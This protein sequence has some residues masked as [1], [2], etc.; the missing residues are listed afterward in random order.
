[1]LVASP[2]REVSARAT[3]LKSLGTRVVIEAKWP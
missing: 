2:V 1:M 3:A